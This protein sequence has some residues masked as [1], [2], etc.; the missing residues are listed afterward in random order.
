MTTPREV[1]RDA[2]NSTAGRDA[3]AAARDAAATARSVGDDV[4]EFAGK[5]SDKA[6]EQLGRAQD[7]AVDAYD[8]AYRYARRNPLTAIGIALGVG[9]VFGALTTARR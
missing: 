6:G 2:A 1:Y 8:D 7:M 4:S 9:F 5:V 3:A